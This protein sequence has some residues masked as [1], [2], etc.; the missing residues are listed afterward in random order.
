ME[1][2]ENGGMGEKKKIRSGFPRPFG[3]HGW[4]GRVE[5]VWVDEMQRGQEEDEEDEGW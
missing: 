5:S 1:R 4:V 2:E 3:M